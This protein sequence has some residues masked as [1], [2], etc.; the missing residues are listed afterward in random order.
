MSRMMEHSISAS[1]AQMRKLINGGAITLKPSQIGVD[2][3]HSVMVMPQTARRMAT[4]MRKN[5]GVRLA[6]KPEEDIL[7]MT[8]GGKVS[9]KGVTKSIKKGVSKGTDVVKR[10]FDKTIVDSG[11]GKQIAKHLIDAGTQVILPAAL[12]AASMA[13]GDPT[14]LSGEMLGNIAGNE[15]D[16][17]AAR[18]GYGVRKGKGVFKTIKKVTGINKKD[19]V[20]VAKDVGKTAIRVGAQAAGDAITAYTGNPAAGMA[21]ERIAVAGADKAIDSGSAKKAMSASAKQAKRVAVEAVDDYV[22]KNLTGVERDVAQKALAGKYPSA[23]DLVYDYGNSKIEDM[24]WKSG[25]GLIPRR[26]RSGMR[27]GT[28]SAYMTPAYHSAMRSATTGAGFRVA[29][30]RVVTPATP[31]SSIIQTGSPYQRFNSPAMSPYISSSPQMPNRIAGGSFLP[32]G[33]RTYG[34]SFV[35]AG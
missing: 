9:L 21:F 4:A 6:L 5:K 10:G 15:L 2:S 31:P 34:G 24:A 33:A 29:D 16:A 17:Y 27:M 1:P 22:D 19:I 3:P 13:L 28:G 18:K 8:E 12:G 25:Y 14:G 32:A 20:K 7:A 30:D 23:K 26:T 35:P 11:V